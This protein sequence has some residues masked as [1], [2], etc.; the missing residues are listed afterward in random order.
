[1]PAPVINGGG[2]SLWKW[3]NFRILRARDLD[4]DLGSGHTAY[5]HASLTMSTY[6]PNF[7]E[8]EENFRGRTD[9]HLRLALL[10]RAR[11][12]RPKNQIK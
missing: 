2:D 10:G 7:I 11:R 5:H 9:G 12:S 6:I 8:I 4:L 3:P 1:L